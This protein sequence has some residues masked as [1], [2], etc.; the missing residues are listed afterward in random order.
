MAG[1]EDWYAAVMVAAP[2]IDLFYGVA[3]G[4]DG[5]GFLDS[6]RN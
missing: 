6:S 5:T 3:T 2:V 4:E 1:H